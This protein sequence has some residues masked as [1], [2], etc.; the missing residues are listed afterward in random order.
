M[1]GKVG[2]GVGSNRSL[3]LPWAC[4]APPPAHGPDGEDGGEDKG[5]DGGEMERKM[6]EDILGCCPGAL[7]AG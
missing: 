1:P 7:V 2:E 6:G 3:H 4:T 5:E